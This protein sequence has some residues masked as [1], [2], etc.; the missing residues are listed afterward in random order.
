MEQRVIYAKC[1]SVSV[2]TKHFNGS[3]TQSRIH[4]GARIEWIPNN[5]YFEPHLKLIRGFAACNIFR[6]HN[7]VKRGICYQH[8]CRDQRNETVCPSV[9]LSHSRVTSKW[10]KIKS[11]TS[12]HYD[13]EM[14]WTLAAKFCDP[15]CVQRS[16]FLSTAK[17][18]MNNLS[19]SAV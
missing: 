19:N 11:Y 1:E 5:K 7:V 8:V 12:H 14:F 17:I 16:S 15:E 4:G 10:F 6:P 13:K 18:G 3:S 2:L 9:C